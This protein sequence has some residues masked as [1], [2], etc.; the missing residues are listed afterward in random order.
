ML[1]SEDH[2]LRTCFNWKH[3]DPCSQTGDEDGL[4]GV[5]R[6]PLVMLVDLVQYG[7]HAV[8]NNLS[9]PHTPAWKTHRRGVSN[10]LCFVLVPS[11]FVHTDKE[12]R[13]R[14]LI[15]KAFSVENLLADLSHPFGL[16]G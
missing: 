10:V 8:V 1:Q 6:G 14:D 11:Q 4:D 3:S 9:V 16:L 5:R 12:A 15:A 2:L 13:S 7:P